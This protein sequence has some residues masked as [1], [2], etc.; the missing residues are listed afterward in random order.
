MYV[1]RVTVQKPDIISI[2]YLRCSLWGP[3]LSVLM[4]IPRKH[5]TLRVSH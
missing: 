3:V 4:S 2:P 1:Y 5:Q